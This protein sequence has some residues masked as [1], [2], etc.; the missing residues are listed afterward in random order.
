MAAA[1]AK[2]VD[3]T[4]ARNEHANSGVA[5]R[6]ARAHRTGK[7]G[8]GANS[9]QSTG[10]GGSSS[11]GGGGGGLSSGNGRASGSVSGGASIASMRVA[12]PTVTYA[13]V[14]GVDAIVAD[15]RELVEWPMTHP[16]I[17]KHL[18]MEPP[19]GA[20]YVCAMISSCLVL[21]C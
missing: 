19:R 11:S 1:A 8:G 20:V 13:D 16:E 5:K 9:G 6:N 10:S 4:R 15:L 18:G 3:S 2:P 21:V 12:A 17:Y 14:G 7:H